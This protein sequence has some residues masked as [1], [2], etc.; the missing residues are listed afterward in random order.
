MNSPEVTVSDPKNKGK[1]G[2]KERK[3]GKVAEGSARATAD[4]VESLYD[5]EDFKHE[6]PK[7]RRLEQQ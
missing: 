1:I 5:E 7:Y 3:E 2:N 6:L 4:I